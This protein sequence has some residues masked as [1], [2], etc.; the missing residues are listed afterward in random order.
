MLSPEN[1]NLFVRDPIVCEDAGLDT[2]D[3]VRPRQD[4]P[5]SGLA[6]WGQPTDA[7]SSWKADA[8]VEA[9]R[10]KREKGIVEFGSTS[11]RDARGCVFDPAHAWRSFWLRRSR[12]RKPSY[13]VPWRSSSGGSGCSAN[14]GA[15]ADRRRAT[16][17]GAPSSTSFGVGWTLR[18]ASG[19]VRP[20]LQRLRPSLVGRPIQHRRV[21]CGL[22]CLESPWDHL[23]VVGA[24]GGSHVQ[25]RNPH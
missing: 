19:L 23:R 16:C 25:P 1:R 3:S 18:V 21:A 24:R 20:F 17:T 11:V 6:R 8:R 7:S 12:R 15:D 5:W 13:S 22:G 4:G 14:C 2:P 10:I 9:D